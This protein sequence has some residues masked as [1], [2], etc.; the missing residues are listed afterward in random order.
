MIDAG[1]EQTDEC[2]NVAA[3][4]R[5]ESGHEDFLVGEGRVRCEECGLV[6]SR[7]LLGRERRC[8][9]AQ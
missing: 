1:G 5:E 7:D 6:I 4:H 9:V 8:P 2:R 3:E